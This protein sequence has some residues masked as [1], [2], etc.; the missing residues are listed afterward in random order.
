MHTSSAD[1]VTVDVSSAPTFTSSNG[2]GSKSRIE[3]KGASLSKE[4]E[5]VLDLSA[6][7]TRV[8]AVSAFKSGDAV[9]LE[10]DRATDVLPKVV[11]QG[12]SLLWTFARAG[13]SPSSETGIGLDGGTARKTRT[14]ARE[15]GVGGLP[16]VE[17]S[18]NDAVVRARSGDAII[19]TRSAPEEAGAFSPAVTGQQREGRFNGRRIDLDLKDADIHNVLRLL[20]DVGR[21]NIVT[22]DDVTGNVTIRMRNVPWDQALD[23]VLQAKGLGMVRQGNL[24]RVAPLADLEQGARAAPSRGASRSSSSR[25]SRR[26]SSRSATRRPRSSRRARRTCSRRAARSPST[27]APTCSSRATSPAT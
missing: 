11:A 23:V 14:V 8:R 3:L 22:A 15:A 17:T 4:L 21:V 10:A 9:I 26:G 20:A 25:R 18:F 24:I 1:T 27:S 5:R 13:D 2:P 19:E 6:T 12:N 16:E 7:S